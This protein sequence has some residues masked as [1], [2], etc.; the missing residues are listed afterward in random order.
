MSQAPLMIMPVATISPAGLIWR[1][2][3]DPFMVHRVIVVRVFAEPRAVSKR[4]RRARRIFCERVQASN[5]LLQAA[6][7]TCEGVLPAALKLLAGK[8]WSKLV[9]SLRSA[10]SRA[11]SFRQ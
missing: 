7:R 10:Q 11:E 5:T 3:V 1:P 2:L 9:L 4:V 8:S 6:G